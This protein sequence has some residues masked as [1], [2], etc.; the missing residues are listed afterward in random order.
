MVDT[1]RGWQLNDPVSQTVN[2]V[3]FDAKG[4]AEAA[5]SA[6]RLDG[7]AGTDRPSIC[8]EPTTRRASLVAGT[9]ADTPEL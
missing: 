3:A 6:D 7:D 9:H 2:R 4:A 5:L 1:V 8:P